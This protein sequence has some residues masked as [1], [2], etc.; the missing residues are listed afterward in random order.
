[1]GV[2]GQSPLPRDRLCHVGDGGI[3]QVRTQWRM[4]RLV[5]VRKLMG[6]EKYFR[7]IGNKDMDSRF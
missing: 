6:L 1:M 2:D 3:Q 7:W 4:V 5:V